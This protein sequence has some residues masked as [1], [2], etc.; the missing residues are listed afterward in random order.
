MRGERQSE[1][2][3]RGG[4]GREGEGRGGVRREEENMREDKMRKVCR[5]FSVVVECEWAGSMVRS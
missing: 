3:R 5:Y 1:V 2:E 4:E